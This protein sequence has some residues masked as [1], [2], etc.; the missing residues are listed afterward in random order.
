M[1][2][3]QI[4]ALVCNFSSSSGITAR[5]NHGDVETLFH[6]FGHALHSL[7]SRTVICLFF[8]IMASSMATFITCF[9]FLIFECRNIS[10]SL[11]LGLL[12]M[13]LKLPQTSLSM[14]DSV[15]TYSK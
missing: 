5:L 3:F 6:E 12:L 13:W 7:L 10:I 15:F 9:Y 4:V 11:V 8:L 14:Y 1:V 2:D